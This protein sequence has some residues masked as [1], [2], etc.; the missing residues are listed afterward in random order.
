MRFRSASFF[1]E[2]VRFINTN[3]KL[4]D[5]NR[6]PNQRLIKVFAVRIIPFWLDEVETSR[7][8]IVQLK[9][10]LCSVCLLSDPFGFNAG[11]HN[12]IIIYFLEHLASLD[13]FKWKLRCNYNIILCCSSPITAELN[14][15]KKKKIITELANRYTFGVG[16]IWMCIVNHLNNLV[17]ICC[18]SEP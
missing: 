8:I 2:C 17:G 7:W 1:L 10:I 18:R 6:N 4:R 9:S 5:V 14:R 12:R 15:K 16:G 13:G 3:H 11:G